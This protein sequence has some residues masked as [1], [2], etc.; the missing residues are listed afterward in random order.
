MTDKKKKPDIEPEEQVEE[1]AMEG[2]PEV[3]QK[4]EVDAL[5][6]EVEQYKTKYLRAIADYQNFERRMMEQQKELRN[7][8]KADVIQMF[9]PTLDTLHKAEMFIKDPGLKMVMDQFNQTFEQAG[10]K[11]MDL[12][13]KEFDPHMAEVIDVVEGEEDNIITEVLRKGYTLNGNVIQH[14]QVKVSKKKEN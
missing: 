2:D 9:L 3:N 1:V 5:K 7:I 14:A 6:E 13:G 11:E 8:I 10:V 12:V 4:S